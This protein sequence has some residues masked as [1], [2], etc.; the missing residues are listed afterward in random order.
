MKVLILL[1][2]R[3]LAVSDTL[4]FA[5][6]AEHVPLVAELTLADLYATFVLILESELGRTHFN[7]DYLIVKIMVFHCERR[8]NVWF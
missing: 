1:S 5:L 2:A 7:N 4:A 8:A 3:F 6:D